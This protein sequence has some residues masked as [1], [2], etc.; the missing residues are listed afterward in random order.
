MPGGSSCITVGNNEGL[1]LMLALEEPSVEVYDSGEG[2]L[3]PDSL[4][5]VVS[6]ILHTPLL[7]LQPLLVPQ[8]S[9]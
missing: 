4:L 1:G 7:L 8:Y 2:E 5:Q 6:H 9:P 3:L